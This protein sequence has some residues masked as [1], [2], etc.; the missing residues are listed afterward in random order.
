MNPEELKNGWIKINNFDP[1]LRRESCDKLLR[2]YNYKLKKWKKKKKKRISSYTKIFN[3][4]LNKD[5]SLE[6]VDYL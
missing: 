1:Q 2:E 4:I 3:N 5:L 6:I